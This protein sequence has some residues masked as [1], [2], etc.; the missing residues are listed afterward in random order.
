MIESVPG[1]AIAQLLGA[2]AGRADSTPFLAG[3]EVPTLVIGSDED[4]I[5][6]ASEAREW[7]R[8]IPARGTDTFFVP[9]LH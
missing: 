3:I 2:L 5:T 1:E 7:S 6:P 8:A 9:V 4:T